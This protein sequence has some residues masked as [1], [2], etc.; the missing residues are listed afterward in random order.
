MKEHGQSG[1][2]DEFRDLDLFFLVREGT[3][4]PT[5]DR[6]TRDPA[7]QRLYDWTDAQ[8]L[9]GGPA[10]LIAGTEEV[11]RSYDTLTYRVTQEG[12][13]LYGKKLE[14]VV[15]GVEVP[16]DFDRGELWDLVNSL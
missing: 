13:L 7:Y 15:P 16:P 5:Y 8:G 10:P 2:A 11:V 6:V 3:S 1:E 14:E 9:E 12:L 4:G